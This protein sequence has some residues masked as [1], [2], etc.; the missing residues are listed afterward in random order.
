[1]DFDGRNVRQ[2]TS[3]KSISISPSG[4]GRQGRLHLLRAPLS[5]RS[6]R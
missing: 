6:G 3:H 4:R 2:L 5:R 1:M